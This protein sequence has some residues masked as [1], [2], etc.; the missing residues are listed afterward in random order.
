MERVSYVPRKIAS[1]L[2]AGGK[3]NAVCDA[4]VRA[5]WATTAGRQAD[6][7]LVA[8]VGA[9]LEREVGRSKTLIARQHC[10]LVKRSEFHR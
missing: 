5:K 6:R 3:V 9:P 7:A 8:C 4:N 2:G 1:L 10:E